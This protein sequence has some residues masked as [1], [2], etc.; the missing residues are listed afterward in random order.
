MGLGIEFQELGRFLDDCEQREGV[1]ERVDVAEVRSAGGEGLAATV[2]LTLSVD[3]GAGSGATLSDPHVCSDGRLR[4]ALDGTDGLL[5]AADHDVAVEPTDVTQA[6]DGTVTVTLDATV[7]A[8]GGQGSAGKPGEGRA[9]AALADGNGPAQRDGVVADAAVGGADGVAAAATA[10]EPVEEAGE[11]AAEEP[12]DGADEDRGIGRERDVPPFK[13]PD[14]L[15]DVYDSYD[16]FAEMADALA[17]DV[18]AETVRRYM[19]DY[20]IH[21]PNTYRTGGDDAAGTGADDGGQPV[22]LS[23][24]IGLPDDV[25]VDALVETVK[26]SNTIYEVTQDIDIDRDDALEML[27]D[28]NLL[29]LVVGRLATEGERDITRADIVG[30]LR[31]A[32]A[33]Q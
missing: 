24:G 3:L 11:A 30:R 7:P 26:R 6:A 21:E 22:V 14:L 2:D 25:T 27:Q 29:D 8:D 5:P 10:G 4:F 20:D 16:T 12:G 32:S 13:D 31:E 1:V 15:A 19:I 18:T 28:L 33:V 23:D 17:M 9:R